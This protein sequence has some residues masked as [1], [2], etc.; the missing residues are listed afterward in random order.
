MKS[1]TLTPLER[2]TRSN[3]PTSE[4][5]GHLNRS[6]QTLRL[7]ACRENGPIRPVR[8]HGRLAWPVAE[9]KQLVGVPA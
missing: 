9:I 7:W 6:E 2:E 8:V 4:A 5:A 3:L 1:V